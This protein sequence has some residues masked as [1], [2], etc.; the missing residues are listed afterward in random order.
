MCR[1]RKGPQTVQHIIC[2]CPLLEN[3]R[4]KLN[5]SDKDRKL[6]SEL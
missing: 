6:A 1:Y 3:E 5:S 2:D 4:E